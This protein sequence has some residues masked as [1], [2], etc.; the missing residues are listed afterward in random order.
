MRLHSCRNGHPL[1]FGANAF[2]QTDVPPAFA[3]VHLQD[4]GGIAW[5]MVDGCI[6][7]QEIRPHLGN[8]DGT[9]VDQQPH[10]HLGGVAAL[11]R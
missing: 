4:H 9:A 2:G 3:L 5:R 1:G 8:G 10:F 6:H 11:T 7:E